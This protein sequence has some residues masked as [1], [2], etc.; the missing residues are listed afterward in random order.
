[1]CRTRG[2]NDGNDNAVWKQANGM[3]VVM[4]TKQ[5]NN[6]VQNTVNITPWQTINRDMRKLRPWRQRNACAA[7]HMAFDVA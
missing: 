1:M 5:T 4:T 3:Y 7:I 2:N 6:N